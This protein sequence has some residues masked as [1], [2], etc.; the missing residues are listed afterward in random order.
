MPF[1][2]PLG[3]ADV[4]VPAG[5]SIIVGA[6][7]INVAKVLYGAGQNPTVYYQQGIVSGGSTV[8]GSFAAA[9]LVRIE[10]GAGDTEYVVGAAPQLTRVNVS[11][12]PTIQM[13]ASQRIQKSAAN[14][15]TAK[16]G[17]GQSGATA[18]AA[19][20]NRFTTVGS[21]ADS[22]LLP[23]AVPGMEIAV[24]N[25]AASNSMTVYPATGEI[26]NALSANA[27]FAVAANKT[28]VFYC[29]VAGQ[30]NSVLTA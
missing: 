29:A 26:I 16:V 22:A 20:I 11:Q 5:Q 12:M 23:A 1:L 7:G 15:L 4:T 8:F 28:A 30:W 13:G 14:A 17:G 18:L 2:G 27:G 24:T 21:A 3:T 9:Q 25:A 10:G 19:D 6:N